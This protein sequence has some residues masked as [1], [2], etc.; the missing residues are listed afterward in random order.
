[1]GI[2]QVIFVIMATMDITIDLCRH[3]LQKQGKYNVWG[4]LIF[5]A[6]VV[7]LLYYGGFFG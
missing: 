2:P 1:M 7:V 5:Y 6:G 3:G 4:S